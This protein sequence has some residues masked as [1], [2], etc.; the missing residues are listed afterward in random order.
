MRPFQHLRLLTIAR[1]VAGLFVTALRPQ[2]AERTPLSGEQFS[3]SR[4]EGDEGPGFVQREPAALDRES[5]ARAVL[6]RAAAVTEQKRPVDFLDVD[7]TLNRLDR[8]RDFED[9]AGGFDDA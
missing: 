3:A 6:D 5:D 7:A 2:I 1:P 4:R 8:I 9:S